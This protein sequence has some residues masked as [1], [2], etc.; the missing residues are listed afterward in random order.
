MI[1]GGEEEIIQWEVIVFI[2]INSD[3]NM[4]WVL[5]VHCQ[6]LIGR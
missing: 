1:V 6:L 3:V 4:A 5:A 2:I